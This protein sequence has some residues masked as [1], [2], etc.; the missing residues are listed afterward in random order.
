M[1]DRRRDT[2]VTFEARTTTQDPLYGATVE[3]DWTKHCDAWAEVQDVL[4]SR[5]ESIDQSVSIQSRPARIRIDQFD[6]VGITAAMRVRIPADAVWPER[7]LRIISGPAFVQKSRELEFMAEQL[8]TE[9][10]D[11]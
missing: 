5:S 7:V 8:S 10:Q 1:R 6:G 3:G 2:F 9:G 11:A 4:P